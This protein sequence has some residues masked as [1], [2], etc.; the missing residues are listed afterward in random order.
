MGGLLKL[1]GSSAK[2]EGKKRRM[3]ENNRLSVKTPDVALVVKFTR[4][5]IH[6]DKRPSF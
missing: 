2:G 6:W 4:L 3:V 5:E 1:C